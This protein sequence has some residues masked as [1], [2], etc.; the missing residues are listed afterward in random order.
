MILVKLF[1]QKVGIL[2]ES[3]RQIEF[4]YT[5]EFLNSDIEL[6][7][8]LLPLQKGIFKFT[9]RNDK[10][11][12]GLPEFIA[13]ALPDKFGNQLIDSYFA[14]KGRSPASIT[15]L[16]RLSYTGAKAIGALEFEPVESSGSNYGQALEIKKIVADARKAIQGDLQDISSDFIQ[17]GS[18]AGGA[19][20][21]A[22]I[23]M[24]P[25]T[26]KVL[27]G[28]D[29]VPEQFEHFL[30]KFDGVNIDGNKM[31]PQK[32]T[33]IE[34]AYYLM[35][36]DCGI[37]I[38]NCSLVN[39][40]ESQHFITSRFDRKGNDKIHTQ[41]MCGMTGID[42][43]VPQIAGYKDLFSTILNLG[44]GASDQKEAFT[45]MVFNVLAVN[46]DDHTKNH[47][48]IMSRTGE[49]SLSPAYDLT[50][51]FSKNVAAWTKEHSLLINGKGIGITAK[52]MLVEASLLSL[53]DSEKIEI[54][55]NVSEVIMDNWHEYATRSGVSSQKILSIKSDLETANKE[56][57]IMKKEANFVNLGI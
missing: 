23:A 25:K 33:N 8:L 15:V 22:L 12:K 2:R 20:P 21:K 31:E 13:D 39:E 53:S 3:F 52:D 34:Y 14:S 19:R 47:S 6:S 28:N 30:I 1:G 40:A 41:T 10:T 57:L 4:S 16:E 50:H 38:Q 18:S 32:Y 9:N 48:F 44:L 46:H 56:A 43:D 11:F 36:N 5:Q 37:N 27:A 26:K 7:P 42:F 45:R 35:A 49:W 54:I 29:L 51:N 17:I 24:H 55:Q